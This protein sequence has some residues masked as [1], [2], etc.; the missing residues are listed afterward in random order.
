MKQLPFG[1]E[2]QKL[3]D[4]N[5]EN[6]I[7]NGA[8][9]FCRSYSASKVNTP[10]IVEKKLSKT[11]YQIDIT[12]PHSTSNR[13][14]SLRRIT[15]LRDD[16]TSSSSP[17]I[18]NLNEN[19]SQHSSKQFYNDISTNLHLTTN[20]LTL[21]PEKR[22][23]CSLPLE[24]LHSILG[25]LNLTKQ[26]TES[27]ANSGELNISLYDN[28]SA[29]SKVLCLYCDRTFNNQQQMLKHSD[30]T[31]RLL[32]KRRSSTRVITAASI[33]D[34]SSCC[35][36][37]NKGIMLS[38]ASQDLPRLF[39]HMIKFH[40][41]QYHACEHCFMRF[42][43]EESRQAH[44]HLMHRTVP[45]IIP[46]SKAALKAFSAGIPV[47]CSAKVS[48]LN[49][50][51]TNLQENEKQLEDDLTKNEYGEEHLHRPT[52]PT[53]SSEDRIRSNICLRSSQRNSKEQ[54]LNN[55]VNACESKS[56]RLKKSERLIMRQTEPMLLSRLGIAQHRLPRQSSRLLAAAAPTSLVPSDISVS[57]ITRVTKKKIQTSIAEEVFVT[58]NSNEKVMK[59]KRS[60]TSISTI[61]SSAIFR[62]AIDI[63]DIRSK[64]H[65]NSSTSCMVTACNI[66]NNFQYRRSSGSAT[67]S[68]SGIGNSGI[69]IG[70][71]AVHGTT[72]NFNTCLSNSFALFDEDFY[73]NVTK[74]VHQ[75]LSCYLD[76]KL[77][78]SMPNTPSPI[79]PVA[80]MPAVRSTVVKSPFSTESMIHEA[81]NLPTVTVSFPTLLTAEQYGRD[82]V[83][84]L[85]VVSKTRKPITKQSWKWKWDFVKKYKYV[86]EN[87]RIVKKIKQPTM[88]LRDLTKLDMWTQLSMRSK[89]EYSSKHVG[90]MQ[91]FSD[92]PIIEV[93]AVLRQEKRIMVEQLNQ[94]LNARLFPPIDL[95][96]QDQ[97]KVKLE[98]NMVVEPP[99]RDL[100]SNVVQR[101]AST[102]IN[103]SLSFA[104]HQEQEFLQTLQLVQLIKHPYQDSVVLS[105]EWAR[106]R[107]YV[108]YG[109]GRK[110]ASLKQM[111]EHHIARH[112][113]VYSTFYEIVGRELIEKHLY[114][115]FFIPLTALRMQR[116]YCVQYL[117]ASMIND[118]SS[119]TWSNSQR[120]AIIGNHEIKNEDSS[121]NEA[122][123]FS[124][125]TSASSSTSSSYSTSF[126]SSAVTMLSSLIGENC[127]R[128][129]ITPNAEITSSAFGQDC[130]PIVCSK[131]FKKC[132]NLLMLYAH[133]LHC[134]NDYFWLQAKKRMKY[135]RAKRR[136]SG[137]YRNSI[138]NFAMAL[139]GS[140][141]NEQKPHQFMI[142]TMSAEPT[143]LFLPSV[144]P[145]TILEDNINANTS[146]LAAS[147]G[148]QKKN[149]SLKLK[150]SDG[151]IVK[152]LLANLPEK[153]NSRQLSQMK[154]NDKHTRNRSN[155]S[156]FLNVET[157]KLCKL[158][159]N[160]VAKSLTFSRA[161][162]RRATENSL[163][164]NARK[165]KKSLPNLGKLSLIKKNQ[166]K[167][168]NG[169]QPCSPSTNATMS[170]ALKLPS[171]SSP[172]AIS[173]NSTAS[174]LEVEKTLENPRITKKES[175]SILSRNVTLK[176]AR[177]KNQVSKNKLIPK[178]TVVITNAAKWRR[179]TL[180][181]R[182][183]STIHRRALRNHS[184]ERNEKK[185]TTVTNNKKADAENFVSDAKPAESCSRI[186]QEFVQS[187]KLISNVSVEQTSN[188]NEY[189]KTINHSS[190]E[191]TLEDDNG[192]SLAYSQSDILQT[193]SNEPSQALPLQ[194]NSAHSTPGDEVRQPH[195]V[196]VKN[197]SPLLLDTL[198]QPSK[199]EESCVNYIGSS[200]SLAMGGQPLAHKR[201][202]KKLNECIAMLT[203]KLSERLGVDFFGQTDSNGS[204]ELNSSVP[205]SIS[206]QLKSSS[207][208]NEIVNIPEKSTCN[209]NLCE[210]LILPESYKNS[211]IGGKALGEPNTL[212]IPGNNVLA[213]FKSLSKDVSSFEHPVHNSWV[214]TSLHQTPEMP[215]T[216]LL[217]QSVDQSASRTSRTSCTKELKMASQEKSMTTIISPIDKRSDP[218]LA[219]FN[220]AQLPE[221]SDEPLNLCKNNS[222]CSNID[223]PTSNYSQD[224]LPNLAQKCRQTSLVFGGLPGAKSHSRAPHQ[225]QQLAMSHD[226]SYQHYINNRMT[227]QQQEI[228]ESTLNIGGV[229]ALNSLSVKTKDGGGNLASIKLP[230]GLIIERVECKPSR[231]IVSKQ[232]PSVTIV[233]RNRSP[234]R[235]VD[236]RN[237]NAPSC[238]IGNP[239]FDRQRQNHQQSHA[240]NVFPTLMDKPADGRSVGTSLKANENV[241]QEFHGRQQEFRKKNNELSNDIRNVGEKLCHEKGSMI[242]N[243]ISVT[244]T[245]A[246]RIEP[247]RAVMEKD[248]LYQTKYNTTTY[249]TGTD[250]QNN[251]QPLQTYADKHGLATLIIPQV[252]MPHSI[253]E[254]PRRKSFFGAIPSKKTFP[255]DINT[256]AMS[257]QNSTENSGST[258]EA[259]RFKDIGLKHWSP[260]LSGA[261]LFTMSLSLI[262][263]TVYNTS[264]L[265]HDSHRLA[266]V[267][268]PSHLRPPEIPPLAIPF[269]ESTSCIKHICPQLKPSSVKTL[270]DN[271]HFTTNDELLSTISSVQCSSKSEKNKH[272]NVSKN[273]ITPLKECSSNSSDEHVIISSPPDISK[274]PENVMT[275]E[276]SCE[277]NNEIGIPR[278][279]M[280]LSDKIGLS[281]VIIS[282]VLPLERHVFHSNCNQSNDSLEVRKISSLQEND[283]NEQSCQ[284]TQL[285]IKHAEHTIEYVPKTPPTLG[286]RD[287]KGDVTKS[288]II[289]MSKLD[290]P[291]IALTDAEQKIETNNQLENV[292]QEQQYSTKVTAIRKK[293]KGESEISTQHVET[294]PDSVKSTSDNG[295]ASPMQK[296]ARKRR[297]NELASILSDQLLESFKEV[298]KSK[299]ND[300][301]FLH[302]ITCQ[303]PDVKFSLEQIPQLAKRKSNPPKQE[304]FESFARGATEN[305]NKLN[306]PFTGR[307]NFRS[308]TTVR[309]TRCESVSSSDL[310]NSQRLSLEPINNLIRES[311]VKQ[312]FPSEEVA[313]ITTSLKQSDMRPIKRNRKHCNESAMAVV[314]KVDKTLTTLQTDE[315][316][317][318]DSATMAR[319]KNKSKTI[320]TL[321]G[322]K[323]KEQHNVV[324][325][326][327]NGSTDTTKEK[328]I[329]RNAIE[330]TVNR[331]SRY[332]TIACNKP[333][334]DKTIAL[335]KDGMKM[336]LGV[337]SGRSIKQDIGR[338]ESK[339]N[340][341]TDD[342]FVNASL[343]ETILPEQNVSKTNSELSSA[344][345]VIGPKLQPICETVGRITRRKS[346]FVDRNLTQY[347]CE[348]K[349]PEV[350][351]FKDDLILTSLREIRNQGNK[352]LSLVNNFVEA[353]LKSRDPRRRLMQNSLKTEQCNAIP[354]QEKQQSKSFPLI[355]SEPAITG[356]NTCKVIDEGEQHSPDDPTSENIS[357]MTSARQKEK[358][359]IRRILT[360]R[361]SVFVRIPTPE[362]A[363][364]TSSGETV[365][366]PSTRSDENIRMISNET[367]RIYRRR[368]SIYHLPSELL[369]ETQ[370]QAT[371]NTLENVAKHPERKPKQSTT[372]NRSKMTSKGESLRGKCD[373]L[374]E[375]LLLQPD[376]SSHGGV[377]KRTTKNSQIAETFSKLFNIQ[378]EIML[379]DSTKRK[380]KKNNNVSNALLTKEAATVEQCAEQ[381]TMQA[382]DFFPFAS[383]S[384][385]QT[386]EDV[387]PTKNINYAGSDTAMYGDSCGD[388]IS[389]GCLI[390]SQNSGRVEYSNEKRLIALEQPSI[391]TTTLP[392]SK[393]SG[394]SMSVI[395][396]ESTMNTDGMDDNM[397]VTTDI[398]LKNVTGASGRR[399][400]KR[401]ISVR[402]G[403]KIQRQRAKAHAEIGKPVVTYN[404]DLCTK[405]FKKLDAYNKH[406]ITLT[407][408]AKLSEQEFLLSQQRLLVPND[409]KQPAVCDR[410][411][412]AMT[413]LKCDTIDGSEGRKSFRIDSEAIEENN[414]ASELLEPTT[415]EESV[416]TLSQEEKLFYECCS[417]LKESNTVDTTDDHKMNVTVSLESIGEGCNIPQILDNVNQ[418]SVQLS[419]SRPQSVEMN[420]NTA[421]MSGSCLQIFR[422]LKSSADL[423]TVDVIP[424]SSRN[425][426]SSND[427]P[428]SHSKSTSGICFLPAS[429]SSN[430]NTKI[431][432][433]GALK[434]YDNF[435]VSIPITDLMMA[436]CDETSTVTAD[437]NYVVAKDSRL[438]T[439]A[440]I[441]LCN[442]IPNEFVSIRKN[443]NVEET[444]WQR[445]NEIAPTNDSMSPAEVSAETSDICSTSISYDCSPVSRQRRT[446]NRK[447]GKNEKDGTNLSRQV[448]Q[449]SKSSNRTTRNRVKKN[450]NG[451][452]KSTMMITTESTNAERTTSDADV[453]AFQDSPCEGFIPPSFNS[454]KYSTA[455]RQPK[456]CDSGAT[457][458]NLQS[459][460]PVCID[461]DDSQMS[462]LSFSDRD[463]F[464]Y[465]TN[466]LTDEEEVDE[467]D[468]RNRQNEDVSSSYGSAV[469]A[470]K[471]GGKA[472]VKR[473]CLIMGRI[474]RKGGNKEKIKNKPRVKDTP[475]VMF[476]LNAT[477]ASAS[478]NAVKDFDKLFDTLKNADGVDCK[479]PTKKQFSFPNE[480]TISHE[481]Q[482]KLMETWD[483]EE[484]E[485]FHNDDIMRLLDNDMAE[486]TEKQQLKS[487]LPVN[488]ASQNSHTNKLDDNLNKSQEHIG[489]NSD[490]MLDTPP[491]LGLDVDVDQK[492]SGLGV[493]T[494]YTIRKVM[495]SV[496]LETMSKNNQR[497]INKKKIAR[498]Q[499]CVASNNESTVCREITSIDTFTNHRR[500]VKE[501]A[502]AGALNEISSKL[503]TSIEE[504]ILE[505]SVLISS[506]TITTKFKQKLNSSLQ[507]STIMKQHDGQN[508]NKHKQ[509]LGENEETTNNTLEINNS[510][511]ISIND[512]KLVGPSNIASQNNASDAAISIPGRT[513]LFQSSSRGLKRVHTGGNAVT[514]KF[515]GMKGKNAAVHPVVERENPSSGIKERRHTTHKQRKP[516]VKKMKNLA[517]DPDSDFEDNIKCKKVK[518]KLLE[519]DIEGNLKM[520]KLKSSLNDNTI[521][522]PLQR[523]KRNAGD[524]LYYWSSTS[525]EDNYDSQNSDTRENIELGTS[526]MNSG[527]KIESITTDIVS[528]DPSFRATSS[529]RSQK[530]KLAVS[531]GKASKKLKS[532]SR[533][534]ST[535][536]SSATR[537][538]SQ[539][540][541]KTKTCV[542]Y[543][544]KKTSGNEKNVEEHSSRM[545]KKTKQKCFEGIGPFVHSEVDGF[546]GETSSSSDQLQQH[547][548]IVGDSH[549]K[550]VTLL[551]HAKGKQDS[552][553]A[554]NN[555]RK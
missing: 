193:K 59:T 308:K 176:V 406:C 467:A 250:Q 402:R 346:V 284:R 155:D 46:K 160:S 409:P 159:N 335:V 478:V 226:T 16:A 182:N 241:Q 256:S 125:V 399:K 461:H 497:T 299:L 341:E 445:E 81:T 361:S 268:L 29:I 523:R 82:S 186:L 347:I 114:R 532:D 364:S 506:R 498:P 112:P 116:L 110:F 249:T 61:C 178:G 413:P 329:H 491:T 548:W 118:H 74:N 407:H 21:T 128:S 499:N 505:S 229:P 321:L 14:T 492:C 277:K 158:N 400:R 332:G 192:Q 143:T 80:V 536:K 433:K 263:S 73:E 420:D 219:R 194:R 323:I 367:K 512:G 230:P 267:R 97:R 69:N 543:K 27:E 271:A 451:S 274:S 109:C 242:E 221:L 327:G 481:R 533:K 550:L 57:N 493:V 120:M 203:G 324:A 486:I 64:T 84:N 105:G 175:K 446:T 545:Y 136:R 463:D 448:H 397:S 553:K 513:K 211:M 220:V 514:S 475:N 301:K 24:R 349:P 245:T 304:L 447:C 416:K 51:T 43:D 162:R 363:E 71:S 359:P 66:N 195:L 394:R 374:F 525:D 171:S 336:N 204:H 339:I 313:V 54:S 41:D 539:E 161:A 202:P 469:R 244:I 501:L 290:E 228:R 146:K 454:K 225:Q 408:I 79:S 435:K 47:N 33:T 148:D 500:S 333:A 337:E 191:G 526:T 541:I 334:S 1:S 100:S 507:R 504:H 401:V 554:I 490:V 122:T 78:V 83:A 517:Y 103:D 320:G 294:M 318:D 471:N 300:L 96:Q 212:D 458:E 157:A 428:K 137:G 40:A 140:G 237:L 25:S 421:T 243:H 68:T 345:V 508:N 370:K 36:L 163:N 102:K 17:A 405:F 521:L 111:E 311:M 209:I 354:L 476:N 280:S 18:N 473:K 151:D 167:I 117:H 152:R 76:G 546:D 28:N 20:L 91:I 154:L 236:K 404:C 254:R 427:F 307:N 383:N 240:S 258:N 328:Q 386:T 15:S 381:G 440:D 181:Q 286:L 85:S 208:E 276:R 187:D 185:I 101:S 540:T 37:C 396:D 305:E 544:A 207:K 26:C 135:R 165:L 530:M 314:G 439:L 371:R 449:Q 173:K 133:I 551:A 312:H 259:N 348:T 459:Q 535:S 89:H 389:L 365:L 520:E 141:K 555:R 431:K 549:K 422:N 412:S 355:S 129:I 150:E 198:K 315:A 147:N 63:N 537:K 52:N 527:C 248:S 316:K 292:V 484:Y 415:I 232:I 144:T 60:T 309:K 265:G 170:T 49:S 99:E 262:P 261:N 7:H 387:N 470:S 238:S 113:L 432:T 552:R 11:L 139:P 426:I 538:K 106:P 479:S 455:V 483:S 174:I 388:N 93:S 264:S 218:Q 214:A 441:A 22:L 247:H 130:K 487:I 42:P 179:N 77:D 251:K 252:P 197:S 288:N 437:V 326:D 423:R 442:S 39:K 417:M 65:E 352:S 519:S 172:T 358:S 199:I 269:R 217:K 278:E 529:A 338:S 495:E 395:D 330:S 488:Q 310:T 464:V 90:S 503:P 56:K 233:A 72:S 168:A 142:Q 253:A 375:S 296:V 4:M 377:K 98:S 380:F 477:T 224:I 531:G 166:R 393:A 392:Y 62:S 430:N 58:D 293:N 306:I 350:K 434:G 496:I 376:A 429:H 410:A 87:G 342:K 210:S 414:A 134:S 462:S 511:L 534:V 115:H 382:S 303:T 266:S 465:G 126:N 542:A 443:H 234:L 31:H 425:G 44:L 474:F 94:I 385:S 149:K 362:P 472:D 282:D 200:G 30:R 216:P 289:S 3:P 379:I 482:E 8:S 322:R 260:T 366:P 55:A 222:L 205:V 317:K 353:T 50:S 75:N 279:N 453:Y 34:V 518:R 356:D 368:P 325:D 516:S 372:I 424:K 418:R 444:E 403:S 227:D 124:T 331:G 489:G 88:G 295:V 343:K 515:G 108:C 156:S 92:R 13:R 255:E 239:C 35:S 273:I 95:E 121:S 119:I 12:Q 438:E 206:P 419:V 450:E 460:K 86:N 457:A 189:E 351:S 510:S 48:K 10:K 391:T 23:V 70:G 215:T 509:L 257:S 153:R 53:T 5:L 466:T 502:V 107:C 494:D 411:S 369:Q 283:E 270:C 196:L 246:N 291:N 127:K 522:L 231:P 32:K 164:S 213:N 67:C 9:E 281:P 104:M 19:T 357:K 2:E 275:E 468:M 298:D 456:L 390:P 340:K 547:G 169:S 272:M 131:C 6:D 138:N 235:T 190:D 287:P 378:E 319:L 188:Q 184:S 180:Q 384:M 123:S 302:D 183:L 38:S 480:D 285:P 132:S 360:R 373:P 344:S 485:D 524:M 297:K 436:A 528:K 45:A 398:P 145:K 452:S 177:K 201:R 223:S